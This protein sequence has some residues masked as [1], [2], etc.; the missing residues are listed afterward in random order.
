MRT[1]LLTVD[2][3]T[4]MAYPLLTTFSRS[5]VPE[6]IRPMVKNGEKLA[7]WCG[8]LTLSEVANI[9]KVRF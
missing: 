3:G 5:R 2:V 4:G 6:T 8:R 1:R 9:L 7:V